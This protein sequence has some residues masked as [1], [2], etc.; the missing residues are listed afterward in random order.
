MPLD[1]GTYFARVTGAQNDIQLYQLS[2]AVAGEPE[3]ITWTGQ[4]NSL[5]DLQTTANFDDGSGP[6][7]FANLDT[8]TFDDSASQK[9]VSLV[10]S[11]NPAA[12]VF[13]ASDDY[14]IVGS[15]SLTGGS[16]TVNG[17][18]TVEVA[19]SGNSYSGPTQINGGTLIFSGDT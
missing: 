17:P 13:D 8:V 4:V 10:G 14:Q 2:V 15:G 7:V 5:W 16:L 18:G 3:N 19:T 9:S 1:A 11:L 6:D 12:V